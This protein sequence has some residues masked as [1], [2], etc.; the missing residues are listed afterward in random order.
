VA[1]EGQHVTELERWLSLHREG[2]PLPLG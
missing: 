1:E 2:K